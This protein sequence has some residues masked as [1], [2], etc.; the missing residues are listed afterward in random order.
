MAVSWDGL[1]PSSAAG[2]EQ[3]RPELAAGPEARAQAQGEDALMG[4]A[5]PRRQSRGK[6]PELLAGPAQ[7]RFQSSVFLL[8]SFATTYGK[9]FN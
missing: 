6:R 4:A 8:A 2:S 3:E 7:M 5:R 1:L 9:I